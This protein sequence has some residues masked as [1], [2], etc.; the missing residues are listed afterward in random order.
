MHS[1]LEREGGRREGV[2]KE[3]GR[4][5]ERKGGREGERE[6]GR[7]EGREGGWVTEGEKVEELEHIRD[8]YE[9]CPKPIPRPPH[10]MCL[11]S[12]ASWLVSHSEW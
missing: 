6:G 10:S 7:E 9:V 4:E 3:G 12:T 2:G 8:N 11:C 5:G 1:V